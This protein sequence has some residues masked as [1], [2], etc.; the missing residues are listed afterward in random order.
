MGRGFTNFQAGNQKKAIEEFSA[1]IS[2]NPNT[3]EAWNNRGF[4]RQLQGEFADTLKDDAEATRLALGY[5]LAWVN[6]AWLLSTCRQESVRDGGKAVEAAR[7]GCELTDFQDYNALKALT[8]GFAEQGNFEKAIG[9]QEKAVE[10]SPEIQKTDE[11]KLLQMY[12]DEKP[13]RVVDIS[14]E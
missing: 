1:V 13:F 7:K 6:Q 5:A 4:N 9:W 14:A 10:R 8:A 2:I 12:R 11:E 3:A